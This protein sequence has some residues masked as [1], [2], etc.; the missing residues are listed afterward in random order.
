MVAK[1][2]IKTPFGSSTGTGEEDFKG[3]A[4]NLTSD[5]LFPPTPTLHLGGGREG[6]GVMSLQNFMQRLGRYI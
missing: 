5:E 6:W 4:E 1:K 3:L 2:R